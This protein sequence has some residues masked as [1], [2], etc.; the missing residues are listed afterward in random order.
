MDIKNSQNVIE[1][2]DKAKN[3]ENQIN[4][5]YQENKQK[6]KDAHQEINSDNNQHLE[7]DE[8]IEQLIFESEE[9]KIHELERD[10][11]GEEKRE[12]E[13]KYAEG[14]ENMQEH[15]QEKI[16]EYQE[17]ENVYQ[18]IEEGQEEGEQFNNN[19][20]EQQNN[21][22]EEGY[23]HEHEQFYQY[24][25]EENEQENINYEIEEIKNNSNQN[26][27]KKNLI[28]ISETIMNKEEIIK[29]EE[30][31]NNKRLKKYQRF[32]KNVEYNEKD[33]NVIENQKEEI[34]KIN[35]QDKDNIGK[36]EK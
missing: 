29:K 32:V 2:G 3:N 27:G 26:K 6:E 21:E 30:N 17:E 7:G 19:E 35:N 8:I 22:N 31:N 15:R 13:M 9:E 16:G 14:K 34:I 24:S 10:G 25:G 4:I 36:N 11:V 23:E 5:H 20:E 33:G 12:G 18:S 1:Y 28:K